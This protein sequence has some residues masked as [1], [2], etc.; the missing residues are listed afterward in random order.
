[1]GNFLDLNGLKKV[2]ALADKRYGKK[3]ELIV[4]A[5]GVTSSTTSA[6]VTYNA[7][8]HKLE[9]KF[10]LHQGPQGVRGATGGTGAQGPQG[11]RGPVGAEGPR[12]HQGIQG[13]QGV[14]GATG[15][16]GSQGPQ[17]VRGPI[18]AEGPRGHQGIQGPQGAVTNFWIYSFS[19]RSLR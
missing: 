17:G 1:M 2:V 19:V 16:T 13:P 15:G 14:R 7:D 4:T 11:V 3:D 18:G 12:G 10:G 6:S 5:S 9:F 8:T